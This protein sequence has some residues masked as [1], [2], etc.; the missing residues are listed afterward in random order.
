[1]PPLAVAMLWRA[2]WWARTPLSVTHSMSFAAVSLTRLAQDFGPASTA[3]A[4]TSPDASSE[5][6]AT[7]RTTFSIPVPPVARPERRWAPYRGGARWR[8]AAWRGCRSSDRRGGSPVLPNRPRSE[9]HGCATA[10]SERVDWD[11]DHRRRNPPGEHYRG[12][13]SVGGRQRGG[14]RV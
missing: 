1:M 11:T 9:A 8:D 12:V 10:P 6:I 14:A 7:R 2:C 13:A 4:S 5:R 3:G